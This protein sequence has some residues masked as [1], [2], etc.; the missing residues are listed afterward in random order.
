MSNQDYTKFSKHVEEPVDTPVVL[1]NVSEV[2]TVE[3]EQPEEL[4]HGVVTDCARLNIREE[5]NRE[6]EVLG[7]VNAKDELVI[8]ESESTDEFYKVLMPAGVEGF[9]MKRYVTIIP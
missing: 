6:S 8:V 7:I 1:D 2:E 5:P 4:K 3:T 9:C